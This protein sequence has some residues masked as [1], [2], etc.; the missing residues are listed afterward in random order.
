MYDTSGEGTVYTDNRANVS[1]SS[2]ASHEQQSCAHVPSSASSLTSAQSYPRAKSEDFASSLSLFSS[3]MGL[4]NN[5]AAKVDLP[6]DGCP[7]NRTCF[8][9]I[10]REVDTESRIEDHKS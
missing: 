4:C 3:G 8:E 7:S 6:D 1:V 9:G 10:D 2:S 5:A